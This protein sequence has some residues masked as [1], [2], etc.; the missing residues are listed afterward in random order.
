MADDALVQFVFHAD[1]LGGLSFSQLED[2]NAGPHRD[3]VGNL[4]LADARPWPFALATTPLVF[5]LALLL[6]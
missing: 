4:F 6:R 1:E 3:D 5:E 2:R